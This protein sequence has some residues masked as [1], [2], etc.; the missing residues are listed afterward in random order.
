LDGGP[1]VDSDGGGAVEQSGEGTGH[2]LT[3]GVAE[4]PGLIQEVPRRLVAAI[5]D[6]V[7]GGVVE[8]LPQLRDGDFPHPGVAAGIAGQVLQGGLDHDLAGGSERHPQVAEALAAD[9]PTDQGQPAAEHNRGPLLRLRRREPVPA[10]AEG[11]KGQR[12]DP[13]RQPVPDRKRFHPERAAQ[14]L[15]LI[16]RVA[17]DQGPVTEVHHPQQQRLHRGRLAAARLA[18]NKHVRVGDRHRVVQH[19]AERVSVE[20]TARQHVDADLGSGRRQA[21]GGDERPQHRRLV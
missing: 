9:Q 7:S 6:Q 20:T 1:P 18:E 11:P 13:G 16:L 4:Q 8:Q 14:L 3:E 17:Q 21:G 10:D 5:V 15:V 12:V 2:Q 19:P